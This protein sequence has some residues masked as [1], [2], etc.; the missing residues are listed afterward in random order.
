M[1]ALAEASTYCDGMHEKLLVKTSADNGLY[2]WS[3]QCTFTI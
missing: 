1:K 3:P 2:G